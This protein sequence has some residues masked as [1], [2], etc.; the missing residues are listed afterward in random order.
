MA[1]TQF[2]CKADYWIKPFH[3]NLKIKKNKKNFRIYFCLVLVPVYI[4]VYRLK[5]SE[6]G[7]YH[8]GNHYIDYKKCPPKN[9]GVGSYDF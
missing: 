6:L 9:C 8:T 7:F 4:H 5:D 2:L 1:K 3:T